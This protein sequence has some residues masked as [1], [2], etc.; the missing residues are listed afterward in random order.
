MLGMLKRAA[1]A[2]P[3]ALAKTMTVAQ[4]KDALGRIDERMAARSSSS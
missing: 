1:T 3:N 2:D 4:L